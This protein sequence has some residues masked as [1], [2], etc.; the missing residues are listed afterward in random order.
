MG[1]FVCIGGDVRAA[2]MVAVEK[3]SERASWLLL[4]LGVL[5]HVGLLYKGTFF[6]RGGRLFS[7]LYTKKEG[8]KGREGKGRGDCSLQGKGGECYLQLRQS[9][10]DRDGH[11]AGQWVYLYSGTA[12]TS[13]STMFFSAQRSSATVLGWAAVLLCC[14][15]IQNSKNRK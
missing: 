8:G 3:A 9:K 15:R 4:L 5:V 2:D 14:P 6:K 13:T 1:D 11:V 10:I 7:G 12:I